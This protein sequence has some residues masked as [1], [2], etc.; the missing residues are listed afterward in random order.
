MIVEIDGYQV[1]IDE[2]DKWILDRWTWHVHGDKKRGFCVETTPS[3]RHYRL[4]REI[5]GAPKGVEVDHKNG[6]SLDNRRENLR[7]CN[8][9]QNCMNRG[10]FKN[11]KSGIKGVKH[12]GDRW[13]VRLYANNKL[14]YYASFYTMEEAAEAY[15][16]AARFYHGEYAKT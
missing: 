13:Q 3:G 2:D 6:N 15:K 9:S 16:T 10:V 14:V 11:S 12:I 5:T 8:R 4:H 1:L 7:L